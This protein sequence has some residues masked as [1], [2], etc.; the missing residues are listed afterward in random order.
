MAIKAKIKE[1]EFF[2]GDKIQVS[3]KIQE[4]DKTRIQIFEGIVIAIKGEGENKMFTVRKIAAGGIG[5]ERIWPLNT[6]WIEKIKVIRKGKVKR[7]KLYFLRKAPNN[8][9]FINEN[10]KSGSAR[11]KPRPS[12]SKK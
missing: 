5:V 12:V 10:K 3:Q 6:P 7:A 2:I 8:L 1:T 4:G 11:R 9:K